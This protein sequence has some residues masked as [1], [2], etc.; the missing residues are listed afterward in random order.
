MTKRMF[1]TSFAVLALL[2]TASMVMAQQGQGGGQRG[3]GGQ[4]QGGQRQAGQPGGTGAGFQIGGGGAMGILAIADARAALGVTDDQMQKL[5][6]FAASQRPAGTPG[7][8]QPATLTAEER[9]ART[10]ERAAA[11][12]KN[13]EETLGKEI[14]A[15][16]DI[17]V[18]QRA[19]GLNSLN[20]PAAPAQGGANA[21][22]GGAGFGGGTQLTLDTLRALNLTDD[23]KKKFE[24]AQAKLL[25]ANPPRQQ[26]APGTT[27]TPLTD[28]ERAARQQANT[29]FRAT[30]SALLTAAQKAKAEELMKDV[31]AYLRP[32]PRTPGAGGAN[33]APGAGGGNRGAGGAGA[34][35]NRGAGGAGAGGN[36]GARGAG[37]GN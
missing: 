26:G 7:G 36:R 18:F 16:L 37:A 29:D 11:A 10:A 24:E 20:P 1:L 34:G 14:V 15:K 35:G 12:R 6:D 4:G 33:A 27:P 22:R 25:A 17:M 23:Q 32:Q 13:L 30:V 19:G 8:G 28:D 9:A 5:R 31:P 3:Q 2:A 21:P